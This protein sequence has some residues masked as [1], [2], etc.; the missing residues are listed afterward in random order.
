MGN[1]N[2]KVEII[3]GEEFYDTVEGP[4]PIKQASQFVSSS[5]FANITKEISKVFSGL[6]PLQVMMFLGGLSLQVTNAQIYTG[7]PIS[8]P[9][10]SP[11]GAPTRSPAAYPGWSDD[12]SHDSGALALPLGI[13]LAITCCCMAGFVYYC[14]IKPTCCL[15][16]TGK[17][18]GLFG[19]KKE[20][21]TASPSQQATNVVGDHQDS[22]AR[23]TR[24]QPESKR[25]I[26]EAEYP[27]R[28]PMS[29]GARRN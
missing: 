27:V 22:D 10:F 20:A 2:R 4:A 29:T 13:S 7:K 8:R 5:Q 25:D 17:E 1:E 21:A 12:E 6:T 11:A 19:G 3:D 14:C 28:N 18:F 24:M 15:Y 16:K 23:Y 9:T 26:E